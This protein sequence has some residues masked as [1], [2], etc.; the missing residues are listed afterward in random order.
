MAKYAIVGR[1][2][3]IEREVKEINHT[4]KANKIKSDNF[5]I[6]EQLEKLIM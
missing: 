1:A 6:K 3:T 4:K 2:I 5:T